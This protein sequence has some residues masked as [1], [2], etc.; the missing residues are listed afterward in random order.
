[1]AK[2][3]N[4]EAP[5]LVIFSILLLLSL[6]SLNIHFEIFFSN[7]INVRAFLSMTV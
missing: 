1:M 5:H 7:T 2:K 4:Y 6:S 3:A